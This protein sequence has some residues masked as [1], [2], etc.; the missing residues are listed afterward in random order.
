[1]FQL[2]HHVLPIKPINAGTFAE[3]QFM[4]PHAHRPDV[5]EEVRQ[6]LERQATW[7]AEK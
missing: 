4:K 6:T 1:M 5:L 7:A 3:V 2:L